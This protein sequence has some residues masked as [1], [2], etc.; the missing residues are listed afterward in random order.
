[1]APGHQVSSQALDKDPPIYSTTG[2]SPA[3]EGT[4]L[5][6]TAALSRDLKMKGR[7]VELENISSRE[8]KDDAVNVR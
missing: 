3:L 1:M 8:S 2:H 7:C 4:Q 6:V 5:L